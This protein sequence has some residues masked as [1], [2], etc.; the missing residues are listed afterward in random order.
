M[1]LIE[2]F[3]KTETRLKAIIN[4]QEKAEKRIVEIKNELNT[5][6][7]DYE[8][9][10]L[11]YVDGDE[12]QVNTAN[13]KAVQMETLK[14][15]ITHAELLYNT[16]ENERVIAEKKIVE[17]ECDLKNEY[18]AALINLLNKA[19][20]EAEKQINKVIAKCLVITG[21]LPHNSGMS[22]NGYNRWIDLVTDRA[23]G[24]F[25]RGDK[26]EISGL[27]LPKLVTSDL[28]RSTAYKK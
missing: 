20:E 10:I 22:F 16:I 6:T 17:L 2:E 4:K 13:D 15:A 11:N 23:Y 5:T 14:V 7:N 24:G 27:N 28:V 9:S 21:K 12:K 1:Q 26:K 19:K 25:M 18:E 3:N 8:E